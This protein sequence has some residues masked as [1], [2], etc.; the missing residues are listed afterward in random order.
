MNKMNVNTSMTAE[1]SVGG[2][3]GGMGPI[4]TVVFLDRVIANTEVCRE[5]DHVDLVVSQRSS[6]PDRTAAIL[7]SGSSPL[8]QLTADAQMLEA[9]GAKFLVIPCNTASY[10]APSIAESVS[11]PVVSIVNATLDEVCRRG[12]N[13]VGLLATDGTF[14]ANVYADAAQQRGL[15]IV[16]PLP[17]VQRRVMSVIYDDVKVGRRVEQ[18]VFDELIAHLVDCG[19]DTVVCGCTE[20]SVLYRDLDCPHYVV[21]SIESLA[22]ATV[23]RAGGKLREASVIE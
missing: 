21:D 17:E 2:V 22:R 19:A 8:P 12:G 1:R 9:A 6:T 18:H 23:T 10:F 14:A 7:G 15:E 5:Q 13:R 4:A 20:I 16:A 3:L 11:I